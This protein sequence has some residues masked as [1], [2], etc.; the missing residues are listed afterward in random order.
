MLS[1]KTEIEKATSSNAV[2]IFIAKTMI[3]TFSGDMEKT[4]IYMK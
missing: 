4:T 2:M 3:L 1:I